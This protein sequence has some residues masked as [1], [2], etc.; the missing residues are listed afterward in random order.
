MARKSVGLLT[1]TEG[2]H[3]Y[4]TAQVPGLRLRHSLSL[5]SVHVGKKPKLVEI[6]LQLSRDL[7][8]LP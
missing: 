7:A 2:E 5:L 3:R 1:Q 4:L 6:L 8:I